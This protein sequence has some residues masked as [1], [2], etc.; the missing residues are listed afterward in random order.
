MQ[1]LL[2]KYG[3]VVKNLASELLNCAPGDR[4]L[5]VQEYAARLEVSVGTVQSALDHLQAVG[6]ATFDPRGRLGTFARSLHYPLLWSLAKSRSVIGTMP[7]PYSRR[8]SGLATGIRLQFGRQPVELS[9]R[10]MRGAVNRL[11]ALATGQF[12]WALV[13]SFAAQTAH[14]HGF[15][16]T[17]LFSLGP[18]TYMADHVL[19]MRGTSSGIQDGM[20]VG[21]DL[22]SNDH[23]YLIRAFSRGKSVEF[24]EIEYERG[25]VLIRSGEI[26]ATVWSR[27]DLPADLS[28]LSV[29]ALDYQTEPALMALSEGAIVINRGNL[30]VANVLRAV[31]DQDELVQIQRD[32][33]DLNRLPS[34]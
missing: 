5:P 1:P 29:I 34:Y 28:D 18:A 16:I 12:D 31:L 7:L 23:T 14:A 11:Q 15:D 13:S 24:V 6:S 25:A 8:L 4:L 20:R 22:Q 26:D 21:V 17:V 3:R 32:V 10:F 19:L 33:I 9:L 2:S 27:E 30:P